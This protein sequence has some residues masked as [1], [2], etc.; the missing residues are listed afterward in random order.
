MYESPDSD[1]VPTEDDIPKKKARSRS[2][3]KMIEGGPDEDKYPLVANYLRFF[4][5][6]GG[7]LCSP[8]QLQQKLNLVG[9]ENA[10]FLEESWEKL[11]LSELHVADEI[12]V[13]ALEFRE[14]IQ[15]HLNH[16]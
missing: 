12:E 7:S 3:K 16:Q 11:H 14:L 6:K 1:Y 2:R 10:R 4:L 13:F 15:K 8:Q 9:E 5:T